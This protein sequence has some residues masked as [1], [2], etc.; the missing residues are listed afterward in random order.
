MIMITVEAMMI[1]TV[2][3]FFVLFVL[4]EAPDDNAVA[5]GYAPA[6]LAAMVG[7]TLFASTIYVRSPSFA[8]VAVLE[9]WASASSNNSEKDRPDV[10]HKADYI[11]R[12]IALGGD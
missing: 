5:L 6:W 8:G 4:A 11:D 2:F 10:H 12:R 1:G 9:D 3:L 7:I